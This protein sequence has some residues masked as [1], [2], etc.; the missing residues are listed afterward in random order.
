MESATCLLLYLL[1]GWMLCTSSRAAT[2]GSRDR[3]YGN[4]PAKNVFRLKSPAPSK[5]A[6]PPQPPTITVQGV[7]TI[8]GYPYVLCK[9]MLPAKPP[10]PARE[11]AY[12]LRE[13]EREGEIEVLE[14]NAH[15]GTVMFDNHGVQQRLAPR[16]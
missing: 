15:T 14:I 1:S 6:L 8:P 9:V 5:L 11:I 2:L 16:R 13:G 4:I 10:E 7:T 12:V 3:P